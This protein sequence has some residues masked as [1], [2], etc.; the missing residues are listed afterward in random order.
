VFASMRDEPAG[1]ESCA[2]FGGCN[3]EIYTINPDFLRQ[4]IFI[5]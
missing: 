5:P 1:D 3:S 2:F 4:G